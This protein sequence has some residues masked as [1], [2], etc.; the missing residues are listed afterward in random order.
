MSYYDPF[1]EM[2]RRIYKAVRDTM[3]SFEREFEEVESLIEEV[4]SETR[5]WERMFEERVEEIRGGYIEPL[6][7]IIDRG[8]RYY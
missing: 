4:L 3:R 6:S 5:E 7:T 2:R 8:I 1:E